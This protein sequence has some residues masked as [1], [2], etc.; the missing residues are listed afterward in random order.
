MRPH[1]KSTVFAIIVLFSSLFGSNPLLTRGL[2][3]FS[4]WS[5][6]VNFGQPVNSEF[7]DLHP[8]ISSDGL[9]LY[10]VSTR[11]EGGFGG[12]DIWV[13]RRAS[14]EDPWGEPL[15]LGPNINTVDNDLAPT[16]S[17][18][19][20]WMYF[21]SNRPGG[22][23]GGD[24]YASWRE[25]PEDDFGWQP[26]VNLGCIVNSPAADLGPSYYEDNETGIITLYFASNRL[27][28]GL[29]FDIYASTLGED[30]SWGPGVLV[31]ELSTPQ[32]DSG[33]DIRRDGLEL[34]LASNRPGSL[35]GRLD[36]W[37]S[38]R[39]T[40]L[41]AWSEPV[42]LGSKVNT[43]HV[44]HGPALSFDGTTL[45]FDS[46]RPDGLGSRDLYVITRTKLPE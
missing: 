36:L 18:D 31:E 9:H 41:D 8:A 45:Y 1:S 38:T 7:G 12:E 37:V 13:S 44:E 32:L 20:H 3:K 30:G 24:L 4:E 22:C 10:F 14:L 29:N 23:G 46:D 43:E 11:P 5:E 2:D 26:S 6:P 39:E 17:Y 16:L 28:E 34:F 21:G 40:T 25:D 27:G 33:P 42:N 19:G 15:N 35:D